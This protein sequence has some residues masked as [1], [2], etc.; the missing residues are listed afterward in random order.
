MSEN[1]VNET[2]DITLTKEEFGL[3]CDILSE[4]W[5][6]ERSDLK[7]LINKGNAGTEWGNINGVRQK[8]DLH[9]RVK[10]VTDKFCKIFD[11]LPGEEWRK[12]REE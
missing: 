12:I 8:V 7:S 4:K 11:N 3:V 5:R 6:S 10:S 1:K 2:I 9:D